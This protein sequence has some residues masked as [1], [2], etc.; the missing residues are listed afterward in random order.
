MLLP[1]TSPDNA[2][3]GFGGD[4][5]LVLLAEE[6]LLDCTT[7]EALHETVLPLVPRLAGQPPTAKRAFL[8]G[9][10]RRCCQLLRACGASIDTRTELGYVLGLHDDGLLSPIRDVELALLDVFLDLCSDGGDT[11]VTTPRQS[12]QLQHA[13]LMKQTPVQELVRWPKHAELFAHLAERG[14]LLR[15][16]ARGVA[17]LLESDLSR[18]LR[19]VTIREL[20]ETADALRQGG[21]CLARGLMAS[22]RCSCEPRQVSGS[23][24]SAF[25]DL[26]ACVVPEGLALPTNICRVVSNSLGAAERRVGAK[27]GSVNTARTA[28]EAA[29]LLLQRSLDQPARRPHHSAAIAVKTQ[30]TR[31]LAVTS[32]AAG[33][34]VPPPRHLHVSAR[35]RS[36]PRSRRAM[37]V[38][39]G[40]GMPRT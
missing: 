5:S 9:V 32:T 2:R 15:D 35:P 14:L 37:L 10:T 21:V 8:N 17:K 3:R 6:K 36:A 1:M 29:G 23:R 12:C 24:P 25:A 22:A 26:E 11:A 19:G 27:D 33:D 4:H 20:G 31:P 16:G 34:D 40:T 30:T 39:T 28:L 13:M 7:L 18:R 38:R